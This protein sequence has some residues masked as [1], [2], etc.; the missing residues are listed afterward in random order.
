M[1]SD[2]SFEFER[3]FLVKDASIV[4]Y[5]SGDLLVQGYLLVADNYAVRVRLV[6]DPDSD[7]ERLLH[8]NDPRACLLERSLR[9]SRAFFTVKSPPLNGVRYEAEMDVDADVAV[10][11]CSRSVGCVV[12][13]RYPVIHK[14]DLWVVDV[15]HGKNRPLM[16]AECERD[17]P[18]TGL[19]IPVFCGEE[20]T[21]RPEFTNE[22]LAVRP[23]STWENQ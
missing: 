5:I 8:E 11:I 6:V 18:V 10:N 17:Q 2:E 1:D 12:K 13:T 15:F 22:M 21:D 9:Y 23:Y 7:V 19:E 3:K 16:I 4:D 20:V 14:D